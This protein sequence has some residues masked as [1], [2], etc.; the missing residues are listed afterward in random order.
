MGAAVMLRRDLDVVVVPPAVRFLVLDV[1]IGKMHLVI[2]VRQ[3]VLKRPT[4]DLLVGSIRMS[5]VVVAA[6]VPLM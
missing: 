3:C 2:E 5:V 6:A 1:R 4:A